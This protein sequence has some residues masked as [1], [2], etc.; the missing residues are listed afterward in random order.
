V[1]FFFLILLVILFHKFFFFPPRVR[2]DGKGFHSDLCLWINTL[3]YCC[4]RCCLFFSQQIFYIGIGLL[5]GG[6]FMC[7]VFVATNVSEEVEEEKGTV[8]L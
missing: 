8:F 5:G 4:Y 6:G 7:H 2:G 3:S 1:E